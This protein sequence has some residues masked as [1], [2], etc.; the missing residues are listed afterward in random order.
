MQIFKSEQKLRFF[1][2][3]LL[4]LLWPFRL[5]FSLLEDSLQSSQTIATV[6]PDV[7]CCIYKKAFVCFCDIL[8]INSSKYLFRQQKALTCFF[9]VIYSGYFVV[10]L[11]NSPKFLLIPI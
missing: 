11:V 10:A 6:F 7:V 2:Y 9:A 3:L 8:S 1:T 4:M 5:Q